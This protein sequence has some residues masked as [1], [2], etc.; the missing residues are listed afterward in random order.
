MVVF[1]S[2]GSFEFLTG[3]T[4]RTNCSTGGLNLLKLGHR[5]EISTKMRVMGKIWAG[6]CACTS[7]FN[8]ANSLWAP[9]PHYLK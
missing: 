6:I 3:D 2:S 8:N 4:E 7:Q 1:V 5:L 9:T